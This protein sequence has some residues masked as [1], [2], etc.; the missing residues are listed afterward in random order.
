MNTWGQYFEVK[1][2]HDF[3]EYNKDKILLIPSFGTAKFNQAKFEC[4]NNLGSHTQNVTTNPAIYNG[5][6]RAL[7]SSSNY[8]YYSNT[9]IDKPKPSEYL[10]TI[11]VD[12][13]N[14]QSFNLTNSTTIKYSSVEDLLG[15]FT[16]EMLDLF[17]THFL[18]FCQPPNKSEF[19]VGRGDTTFEE[20]LET[21]EII[22]QYGVNGIIPES[23]Y[24]SIRL[25]YENQENM[26][27][28]P[29]LYRYDLNI[30]EVVK[31]LLMVDKPVS[32]LLNELGGSQNFENKLKKYT[33]QQSQQFINLPCRFIFK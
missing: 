22:N 4:F 7:W 30:H 10:K 32:D 3:R 18:N 23:E 33:K 5:G 8:G 24:S 11:D 16:K 1:N 26:F 15:V 20:F 29:N 6:V 9:M 13:K 27:N 19:L 21:P 31:S 14:P 12:T 25:I 2:N 28:G 17:E